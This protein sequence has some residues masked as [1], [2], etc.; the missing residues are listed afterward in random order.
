MPHPASGFGYLLWCVVGPPTA[1]MLLQRSQHRLP[2]SSAQGDAM[3]M[4]IDVSRSVG[5]L[6]QVDTDCELLGLTPAPQRGRGCHQPTTQPPPVRG[7]QPTA[8]ARGTQPKT[9]TLVLQQMGRSLESHSKHPR[10]T[11][12][13]CCVAAAANCQ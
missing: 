10:G 2:K 8:H 5:F 11:S 4:T 6:G 9:L 1:K 7:C 13:R 3:Q 12:N